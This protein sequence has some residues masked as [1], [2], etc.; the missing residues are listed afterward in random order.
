MQHHNPCFLGCR[1]E[2]HLLNGIHYVNPHI[3]LTMTYQP[4]ISDATTLCQIVHSE[5]HPRGDL[6]L[7]PIGLPVLIPERKSKRAGHFFVDLSTAAP[8]PD[9]DNRTAIDAV[10]FLFR[11]EDDSSNVFFN[12]TVSSIISI[13]IVHMDII[14]L[15]QVYL[16]SIKSYRHHV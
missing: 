1:L 8:Q 13:Q 14:L 16:V 15:L 6:P 9:M 4:F 2:D 11:F 5:Q 10:T 7:D 3:Y 12:W